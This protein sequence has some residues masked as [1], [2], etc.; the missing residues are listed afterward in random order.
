MNK[1]KNYNVY[2]D[3]QGELRLICDG[4]WSKHL[5]SLK[6]EGFIVVQAIYRG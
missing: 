3:Q 2:V 1:P 5:S 6:R 4:D